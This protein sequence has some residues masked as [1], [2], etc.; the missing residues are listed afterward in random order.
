MSPANPQIKE[1]PFLK[2]MFEDDYF[3]DFLVEKVK[4]I[5]VGLCV[6]IEKEKPEDVSD[7]YDLAHEATEEINGLMEEFEDNDSDLE[8][9]ARET[10]AA[11]FEFVAT[12]YG[13]EADVEELIAPRD[14]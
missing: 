11:D 8:T 1:H 5:L 7:L 12:T 13:F 2:E 10:I 3:P 4:A 9:A 14:W 6:R